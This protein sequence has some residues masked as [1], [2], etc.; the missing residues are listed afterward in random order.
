[1]KVWWNRD[2]FFVAYREKSIKTFFVV[3]V[4]VLPVIACFTSWQQCPLRAVH[5][6]PTIHV[7]SSTWNYCIVWQVRNAVVESSWHVDF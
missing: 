1:M 5:I 4:C 2:I 3:N 6:H 7:D